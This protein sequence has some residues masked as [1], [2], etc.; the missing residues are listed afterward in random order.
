[1]ATLPRLKPRSFYDLVVEVA[2]IRPGPDPGRVGAP[3][4]P[5]PQRRGAG[6]LPAPAARAVPGEDARRAAVPG[7][8]HADGDRR[9]RASPRPRPTS[10]ARRWARSARRERME[11]L[12]ERLYDGHGRARHHRR[13][14]PRRSTTKL[15]A[16]AELRLPRE[17]LGELRLPR[18]RELVDQVP[19]PGGVLRGAAQRA[20]DGLLLAAHARARRA[21]PRR[22]RAHARHQRERPRRPT[23]EPC[24]GVAHGAGRAARHRLGASRRRRPGQGHRRGP[25]VPDHGGP[26]PR[27]T[28]ADARPRSK[29]SRPRARSA[30]FDDCD[31]T[32]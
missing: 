24:D 11:R 30:C 12:R 13:R 26:R 18:V 15:E 25:P 29:R 17:P 16:F 4:P 1:M 8:A 27:R 7:A 14:S 19:L 31:A 10:C 9:R 20:A 6:H 32:P 21:P 28:G 2:L 22:R 3:V 5:A 23:L